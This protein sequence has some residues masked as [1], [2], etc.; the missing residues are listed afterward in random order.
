MDLTTALFYAALALIALLA[1]GALFSPVRWGIKLAI[2]AC[3]GVIGLVIAGVFGA[4]VGLTITINWL[5]VGL[6]VVLGV[7]G[8]FLVLLLHLLYSGKQKRLEQV[9]AILLR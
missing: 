9:Q 4:L 7:P 5:S 3:F 6:T 8:L 2:N 1:L